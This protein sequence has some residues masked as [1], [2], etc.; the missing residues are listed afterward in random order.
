MILNER[1]RIRSSGGVVGTLKVEGIKWTR[2]VIVTCSEKKTHQTDAAN[3]CGDALMCDV[4][5]ARA[6]DEVCIHPVADDATH[7]N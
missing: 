3:G 1:N 6:T 2:P 5:A 4:S 7:S